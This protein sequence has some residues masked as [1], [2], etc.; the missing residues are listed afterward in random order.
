MGV[1]SI[2]CAIGLSHT[3]NFQ[4]KSKVSIHERLEA[5]SAYSKFSSMED[6]Y[7]TNSIECTKS[8]KPSRS[9]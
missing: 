8:A 1:A 9:A 5:E 4:L 2:A 6:I 3:F 7:I